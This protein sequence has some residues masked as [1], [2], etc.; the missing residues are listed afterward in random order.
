MV[1]SNQTPRF[2]MSNNC[3][4]ITPECPVEDSVYGYFPSIGA[5]AFFLG[6]FALFCVLNLGLGF[7]YKTWS[8]MVALSFGCLTETIG[9]VGRIIMHSN[10]YADAGFLTLK[11]I[12]PC[13]GPQFSFIKPRFYTYIFIAAD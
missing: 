11:H 13:F 12:A 3:T 2:I 9:Y 7:R 5:N 10:P 4:D 1:H 8:Y 6:F